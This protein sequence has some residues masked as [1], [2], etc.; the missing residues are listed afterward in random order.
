MADKTTS[1]KVASLLK[2]CVFFSRQRHW[3]VHS[4]HRILTTRFPDRFCARFL[5]RWFWPI[6]K[7]RCLSVTID[8]NWWN[9]NWNNFLV[10]CFPSCPEK[11]QP[12]FSQQVLRKKF[13]RANQHNILVVRVLLLTIRR[14]YWSEW[15]YD[16][17]SFARQISSNFG[18]DS[19]PAPLRASS[20]S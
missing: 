17:Q 19:H 2:L 7:V 15:L 11:S 16:W 1:Q 8:F 6:T 13:Q 9:K 4:A 18:I 3:V 12:S 5:Q 20:I 10:H 14:I